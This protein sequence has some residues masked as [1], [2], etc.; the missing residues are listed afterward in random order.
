MSETHIYRKY[1]RSLLTPQ[2]VRE[3]SKL[4]PVLVVR[5]TLLCWLVIVACWVG[6][7][8]YPKWW[9]VALAVVIVGTRAY[10]LMI[11][12]HDGLHRRLCNGVRAN[13]LF[14]DLFI[15]GSFG[16]VTRLNNRNH[17]SHH[18]HLGTDHDPD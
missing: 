12:A 2:R 18:Q 13:D 5:D 14:N 4:R 15:V 16:A 1:R 9:T 17:L 10:A 6:V 11:I 8:A 3:L 7:A